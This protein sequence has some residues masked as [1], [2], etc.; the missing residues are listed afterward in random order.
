MRWADRFEDGLMN[1][2][3]NFGKFWKHVFEFGDE[4]EPE[5]SEDGKEGAEADKAAAAD[6]KDEKPNLEETEAEKK[7]FFF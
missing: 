2:G 6:D 3:K 1:F 7:F 5:V 4:E